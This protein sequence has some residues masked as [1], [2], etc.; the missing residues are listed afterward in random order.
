MTRHMTH[1]MTQPHGGGLQKAK[2]RPL[3]GLHHLVPL[4]SAGKGLGGSRGRGAA[5]RCL[6]Q[7]SS[8]G[9]QRPPA[10]AGNSAIQINAGHRAAQTAGPTSHSGGPGYL[11]S[12]A[13]AQAASATF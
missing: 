5:T 7:K 6:A 10:A 2:T 1:R 9:G 11:L 8:A 12:M 13:P 3:E 4:Y